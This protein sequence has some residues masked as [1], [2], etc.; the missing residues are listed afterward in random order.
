[1]IDGYLKCRFADKCLA[2]YLPLPELETVIRKRRERERVRRLV[3]VEMSGH[4]A[5]RRT[6]S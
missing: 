5:I 6:L 1:M 2:V 4:N 3:Q